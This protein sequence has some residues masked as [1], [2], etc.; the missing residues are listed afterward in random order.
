MVVLEGEV[1]AV[2]DPA[3]TVICE[4]EWYGTEDGGLIHASRDGKYGYADGRGNVVIPHQFDKAEGFRQD[5]TKVRPYQFDEAGMFRQGMAQVSIDDKTRVIQRDGTL[6][7]G[8]GYEFVKIASRSK[9]TFWVGVNGRTGLADETGR[10]VVETLFDEIRENYPPDHVCFVREA[11][12]LWALLDK[13]G[14]ILI[15][16]SFTKVDP[17]FSST[18]YTHYTKVTGEDGGVGLI[19]R[20]GVLHAPCRFEDVKAFAPGKVF[21]RK[22]GEK[23]GLVDREGTFLLEPQFF[24]VKVQG[25]RHALVCVLK[26]EYISGSDKK[27]SVRKWG[28][29]TP[30][31]KVV[32]PLTF[33]AIYYQAP[34]HHDLVVLCDEKK[35]GLYNVRTLTTI[36]PVDFG[37]VYPW[38]NN[39]YAAWSGKYVGL[40]N[41]AGEW[42]LD[43]SSMIKYLPHTLQN[44]CGAIR[45]ESGVGLISDNG[46]IVLPCEYEDVG[47]FS[48]GLVPVKQGGVWGYVNLEGEWLVPPQYEEAGAFRNGLAAVRQDGKVGLIDKQGKTRV[49]FRYA[50]AG[51]VLNG[52]FP[53]A[54]EREGKQQWGIADLAGKIILPPEYDCV[55]WIDLEPGKTRYHGKPGWSEF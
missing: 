22:K 23:W 24:E 27:Q 51:Y 12:S 7:G 26:K 41:H 8:D 48:E 6:L 54:L 35:S 37:A 11:G 38:G 1:T 19:D 53:F 45:T 43:H 28:V 16:P 25:E 29:V 21:V 42:C 47:F 9:R 49:P 52:R 34:P 14:I 20:A 15:P 3:G 30:D 36:L 46:E 17:F 55:E 4:G 40:V 13:S 50:D 33:R 32:V 10:L 39:L 44:G 5:M 18:Y 2:I 31:G